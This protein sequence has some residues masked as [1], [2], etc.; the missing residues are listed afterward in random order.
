MALPRWIPKTET[1]LFC[2]SVMAIASTI[3][4]EDGSGVEVWYICTNTKC[5][6]DFGYEFT[7]KGFVDSLN[8]SNNTPEETRDVLPEEVRM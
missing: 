2:N 7:G 8:K 1:C 6:R 3:V 5:C 4:K